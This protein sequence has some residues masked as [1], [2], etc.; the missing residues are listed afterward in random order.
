M[1]FISKEFEDDKNMIMM[2]Y[3]RIMS[4]IKTFKKNILLQLFSTITLIVLFNIS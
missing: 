2:C 4:I 3:T 1:L